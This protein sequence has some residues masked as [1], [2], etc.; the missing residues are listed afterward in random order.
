MSIVSKTLI[1]SG[2]VLIVLGV[3]WH[4]SNGNIPFGKLPGDI[5]IE[6]GNSKIYIPITTCLLISG[7]LS[8]IS[9]FIS[10]K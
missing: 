1:V 3:I 6:K 10:K 2:V 9:Y 4:F 8:L 5:R 7:V